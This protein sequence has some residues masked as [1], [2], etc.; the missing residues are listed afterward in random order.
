MSSDVKVFKLTTG[1]ELIARAEQERDY[2]V[3]EKPMTLTAVPG[4]QAG[5]M[6]FALVPW[7]MA[8]NTDS[9]RF[10]LSHIVV[11]LDA[12]A[13]IEKNYLASVTGLSL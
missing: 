9:V 11:E 10:S 7:M 4:Q 1:E 8:A 12:T 5:Q 6:G 13:D 2:V 3:L